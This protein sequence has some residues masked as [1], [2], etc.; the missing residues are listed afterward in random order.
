MRAEVIVYPFG[1]IDEALIE[2]VR[3]AVEQR[4]RVQVTIVFG[5]ASSERRNTMNSLR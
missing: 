4:F 2:A 5:E 1:E 3:R